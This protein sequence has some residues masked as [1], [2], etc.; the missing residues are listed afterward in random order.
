M[1]KEQYMQSMSKLLHRLP[2]DDLQKTLEYFEEYFADAG[3]E[4]E[5]QAIE[6]LGTPETAAEQIITNLALANSK[7]PVSNVKKGFHAV[8][9]GVLAVFAAPIA[10][11]LGLMLALTVLMLVFCV[12]MVLGCLFLA[13]VLLLAVSPIS[14]IA[15]FMAISYGF[16]VFLS[17]LGMGLLCA[18]LGLLLF[19]GAV[20][21]SK[22]FLTWLT[23][24]LGKIV[25]KG[26]TH[27]QN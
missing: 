6:D 1:N 11:P 3:P 18:G 15:G 9:V 19:V 21:T 26:A 27:E 23:R 25:R 4:K 20:K 2:K 13:A 8:W 22:G 24:L 14:V 16:P 12:F 10:L 7:E 17:A 5:A